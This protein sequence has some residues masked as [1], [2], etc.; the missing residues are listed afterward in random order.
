MLNLKLIPRFKTKT[1]E[2][3]SHGYDDQESKF[4]VQVAKL[5]AVST[6]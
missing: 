3:I 2:A 1:S 5:K 6:Q 4:I